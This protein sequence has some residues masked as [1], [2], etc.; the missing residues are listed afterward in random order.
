M[1]AHGIEIEGMKTLA[2]TADTMAPAADA[3][4]TE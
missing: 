2:A 4:K 1:E 3:A